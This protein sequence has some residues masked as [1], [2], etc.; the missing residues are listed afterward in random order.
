MN[1]QT[2]VQPTQEL[3]VVA[4]PTTVPNVAPANAGTDASFEGETF[5]QDKETVGEDR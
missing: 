4:A 3:P 2:N 5:A 1:E